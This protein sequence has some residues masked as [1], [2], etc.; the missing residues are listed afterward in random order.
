MNLIAPGTVAAFRF[1]FL[2]LP[3]EEPSNIAALEGAAVVLVPGCGLH[4][5]IAH[6]LIHALLRSRCLLGPFLIAHQQ[7]NYELGLRTPRPQHLEALARAL[8]VDPAA[9]VDYGLETARDALEVLFRLEEG[10]GAR[11]EADAGGARVAVDPA[12]PGAQKLDA[13][14]RVWAAMRARR[15][16]GE[17]SEGE[18]L[19]WKRGFSAK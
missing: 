8:G 5:K 4:A 14:V 6:I 12:A 18:Y 2:E 9:L 10:F 17:I 15:D 16:S 13:A 11:P 3:R 19:D 7:R 1:A